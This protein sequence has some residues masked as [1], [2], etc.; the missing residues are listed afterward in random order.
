[1]KEE[2]AKG[3]EHERSNKNG[4]V[5]STRSRKLQA[6]CDSSCRRKCHLNITEAD[7]QIV[8]QKFWE[9]PTQ[10]GKW[11]FIL[12]NLKINEIEKS[13]LSTPKNK[14][15]KSFFLPRQNGLVQVCKVM[16]LDTLDITDSWVETVVKK[17]EDRFHYT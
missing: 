17:Q 8:F 11:E 1:M 13:N 7:R 12:R 3:L 16:F 6:G 4:E 5:I 14:S 15:T 9:I 10:V 2:F